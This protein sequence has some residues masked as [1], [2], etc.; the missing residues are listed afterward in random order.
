MSIDELSR[1]RTLVGEPG[2]GLTIKLRGVPSVLRGSERVVFPTRHAEL[3][4]YLL[5]LAGDE[6]I[7]AEQL[8]QSLWPDVEADRARNR[9]RTMLW[10]ARGALDDQAWRL[11]RR[12]SAVALD[13][14]GVPIDVDGASQRRSD[15]LVGWAVDDPPVLLRRVR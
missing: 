14:D 5:T 7:P 1:E 8:A 11:T 10:Q 2:Q 9:L 13:L 3:G 12:R 15:L 4:I 6:G